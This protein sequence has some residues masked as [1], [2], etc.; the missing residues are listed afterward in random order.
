MA[1]S[2]DNLE[3]GG[4]EL[5]RG[6][7]RHRPAGDVSAAAS[8]GVDRALSGDWRSGSLAERVDDFRGWL[9]AHAYAEARLVGSVAL[10]VGESVLI[11]PMPSPHAQRLAPDATARADAARVLARTETALAEAAGADYWETPDAFMTEGR[12]SGDTGALPAVAVVMVAIGASAAISYCA[13]QAAQVVDNYLAR[14]DRARAMLQADAQTLKVIE[15][16]TAREDAENR[17]L[18]LDEA[19][20]SVLSALAKRQEALV[21]PAP[22]PV[23]SGTSI[24]NDWFGIPRAV[25]ATGLIGA[26]LYFYAKG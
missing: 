19:S 16:H 20:R 13:H 4:A 12:E 23:S 22:S 10:A 2:W 26:A 8:R 14:S 6:L 18:P 21:T 15:Q 17:V 24:G 1:D 7:W 3:L 25:L 11:D 5:P 9:L